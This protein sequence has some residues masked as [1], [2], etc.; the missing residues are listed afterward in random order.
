[1]YRIAED[2]LDHRLIKEYIPEIVKIL[3][4]GIS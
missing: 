2:H 3:I 4:V 1:M